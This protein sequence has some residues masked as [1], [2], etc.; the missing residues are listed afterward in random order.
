MEG[1]DGLGQANGYHHRRI[2]HSADVYV[3]GTRHTSDWGI[4]AS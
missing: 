2:N 1:F 4:L 3:L